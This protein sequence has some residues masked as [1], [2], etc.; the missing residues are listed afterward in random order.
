VTTHRHDDTAPDR[1][2]TRWPGLLGDERLT[3]AERRRLVEDQALAAAASWPPDD[4]R[5]DA[6]QARAA[7]AEV[8]AQRRDTTRRA[9][10]AAA[11]VGRGRRGRRRPVSSTG[12]GDSRAAGGGRGMPDNGGD[13]GGWRPRLQHR[14]APGA[15]PGIDPLRHGPWSRRTVDRI[16]ALALPPSGRPRSDPFGTAVTWS[17]QPAGWSDPLTP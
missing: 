8:R 15:S 17:P 14:R 13:G 10:W 16:A 12:A 11:G 5:L 4:A 6:R 1:P 2:E 3:P 9:R 7:A